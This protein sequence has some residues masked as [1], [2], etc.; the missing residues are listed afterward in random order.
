MPVGSGEGLA[1]VAAVVLVVTVVVAVVCGMVEVAGAVVEVVALT[2]VTAVVSAG[3][4]ELSLS[5]ATEVISMVLRLILFHL[6][7]RNCT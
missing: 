6:P 4:D 1:V 2:V 7:F 3:F 5:P